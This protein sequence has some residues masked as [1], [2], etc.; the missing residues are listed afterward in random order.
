MNI[1][2]LREKWHRDAEQMVDWHDKA[3]DLM[4]VL[5]EARAELASKSP[6]NPNKVLVDQMAILAK[7]RDDARAEAAFSISEYNA[8]A[9][10]ADDLT[11]QL[12]AAKAKLAESRRAWV[13]DW[14][15]LNNRTVK[16]EADWKSALETN[17]RLT[18]ERDDARSEFLKATQSGKW[19]YAVSLEAQIESLLAELNL[20]MDSGNWI[21]VNQALKI[22]KGRL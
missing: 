9:R 17:K 7:E 22:A 10:R 3:G 15:I 8:L 11:G 1:E 21:H 12:F 13:A 20:A 5:E 14:D 4:A 2:E 18:A 16:V 19:A 6:K